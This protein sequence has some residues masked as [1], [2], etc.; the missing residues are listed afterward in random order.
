[1]KKQAAVKA[2]KAPALKEIQAAQKANEALGI[3][4]KPQVY[5][6][7]YSVAK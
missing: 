7:L 2:V 4:V 5:V 3:T 6:D 1:M